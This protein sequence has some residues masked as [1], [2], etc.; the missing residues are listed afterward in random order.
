MKSYI[1]KLVDY[2]EATFDKNV[3]INCPQKHIEAQMKHLT[4]AF[5]KN[6][7]VETVENGDVTV[8]SLESEIDKFNKPTVFVTVGGGLFNAEFEEKMIG[9]SVGE[10][11]EITV[12]GKA[13]KV[14]VKQAS[15][16][17]FPEPTDEMAAKYAAEHDEFSGIT[18]VEEYR[19]RIVK[20]YIEEQR[21][22]CY[23]KAMDDILAFVLE[24]SD[25]EFDEEE[26]EELT[27][28]EKSFITQQLKEEG[29]D[30]TYGDLTEEEISQHLGAPSREELEKMLR[31]GSEQRIAVA[32]WLATMQ[33]IDSKTAS[34]DDIKGDWKFLEDFVKE[35]LTVTEE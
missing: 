28:E 27:N 4:R 18:T 6:L 35:N 23:Y 16:T 17:V 25:W 30:K 10:T 19:N 2:R 34:V 3:V 32:L 15:R 31:N 29:M 13:V 8:L 22:S 7:S 11:F 20:D 12:D 1:N 14:T 5:K 26:I 9:H 24:N 33:K 21:N